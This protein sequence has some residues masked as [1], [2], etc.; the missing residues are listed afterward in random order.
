[1]TYVVRGASVRAGGATLLD[2]A[3]LELRPGEV[4]AVIGPNGVG[5][6][7]LIRVLAGDLQPGSGSVLLDGRPVASWSAGALAQRRSVMSTEST[8]AFA[9]TAEEVVLLG[10]MPLDGGTPTDADRAVTAALLDAVDCGQLSERVFATLSSG[11][12][13]RV[14][15]A[16][17]I[18]Q[19]AAPARVEGGAGAGRFVLLD[20][21]TSSL[22]PAHQHAAMRLLRDQARA[23]TGILVVLHDLNLVAAYADRVA[24][25]D[26]GRIVE[27]GTPSAVLRPELLERVFDIPML[28]LTH[29]TL[30][31]P[32][33]V[34]D[35][36]GRGSV[37][38]TP[39][40]S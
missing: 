7:T 9:F 25:L 12:R 11:E 13:Q 23:G 18:A 38:A 40:P 10:R 35:P 20:E 19:V 27:V 14:S 5:K 32:L 22:D 39:G 26:D 29:P 6:S 3:S 1:V 17:A 8:V 30:A 16:R 31:H 15:L 28:V 24:L 2:A 34:N 33:I 4:L 36:D 37:K 21:P